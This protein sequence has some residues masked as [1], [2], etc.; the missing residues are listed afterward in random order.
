MAAIKYWLWLR[1]LSGMSNRI[2]LQLLAHFGEAE[3][4]YYADP[5]EYLQVEGLTARQRAA[6][7]DK[8]LDR[9]EEIEEQ[10]ARLGIRMVTMADAAYPDRLRAISDAP[11]LLYCKGTW[12]DFDSEAAVALIGT[13]KATPYGIRIGEQLGYELAKGG[14]YVV[15]GLAAGGDAAGHRGA[16]LAGRRTA[17]VLGGGIDVIYPRENTALY[18]DIAA[19]G[20]LISEYPPGTEP[21][22]HHFLERNRIISGLCVAVIVVEAPLRSGTMNTVHH[23]AEQGR[24]VYAVPGPVDAPCSEGCNR[25]L[26]DGAGAVTRGWDVLSDL[27][28]RFPDRIEAALFDLP[29]SVGRAAAPRGDAAQPDSGSASAPK[30]R[31]EETFDKTEEMAYIEIKNSRDRFT[32]DQI[33]I[34]LTLSQQPMIVDDIAEAAQI[35]VRR[36]LS[37]LTV[38][39]IEQLVTKECGNRY[40]L[41]AVVQP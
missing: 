7:A 3:R 23:A 16:L 11:C 12:P 24:D 19:S 26:Q 39:E 40:T 41:H 37:A 22:G 33:Q 10:C 30:P 38:L 18:E 35:P 14:A 20:V 15:S 25:L 34:L 2:C 4:V 32:D 31:P 21:K 27:R 13:R 36:V 8:R 17:A 1:N 29:P 5:E 6:L 28:L 9:A